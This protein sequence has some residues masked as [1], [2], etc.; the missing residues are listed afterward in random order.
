MGSPPR[1]TLEGSA[2]QGGEQGEEI[3]G[4]GR[5]E[6][7]PLAG[8]GMIE[9]ETRG[10]ERGTR[11]GGEEHAVAAENGSAFVALAGVFGERDGKRTQAGGAVGAVIQQLI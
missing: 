8:G 11:Q 10:V 5:R 2:A 4:E 7:Q 1:S 3:A 9:G 6:A